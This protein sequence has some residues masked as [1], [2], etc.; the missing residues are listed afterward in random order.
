MFG[1][2]LFHRVT[3]LGDGC[4]MVSTIGPSPYL[5][6]TMIFDE[7]D[8]RAYYCEHH[9]NADDLNECHEDVVRRFSAGEI[10]LA[11]EQV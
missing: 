6:E 4:F 3:M 5:P 11:D 1:Y 2:E 10:I 7:R 8:G 9:S